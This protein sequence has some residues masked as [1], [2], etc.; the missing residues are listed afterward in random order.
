MFPSFNEITQRLAL[1]LTAGL[2]L[3][4]AKEK[5]PREAANCQGTYAEPRA[6]PSSPS[7]GAPR[8]SST[9]EQQQL[10]KCAEPATEQL[11]LYFLAR[12]Q[13]NFS[14]TLINTLL[15]QAK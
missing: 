6:A 15:R 4:K 10:E 12:F 9:L 14:F 8:P 13:I 3:W 1:R 11:A 2:W 5:L 7:P